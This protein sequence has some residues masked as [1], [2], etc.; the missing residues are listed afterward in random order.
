MIA[1]TIAFKN[2]KKS[3]NTNLNYCDFSV[4]NLGH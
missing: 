3:T 2:I 4:K 1:G